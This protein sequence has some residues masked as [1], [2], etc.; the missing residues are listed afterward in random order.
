MIHYRRILELADEGLSIRTIAN[1]LGHGRPKVKEVIELA[2]DKDLTCP[3]SEEMDD[4]WLEV[5]LF[6]HKTM[7]GSGYALMDFD[8][9]HRAGK[10]R[11]EPCI[12]SPRI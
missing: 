9:I 11:C 8:Q 3:L 6:P 4:R 12:A 1:S 7:E 2:K 10:T 5:F